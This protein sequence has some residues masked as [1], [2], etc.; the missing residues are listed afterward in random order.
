MFHT[1]TEALNTIPENILHRFTFIFVTSNIKE[2]ASF[3]KQPP[4]VFFKMLENSQE[5]KV[6]GLSLQIL[7]KK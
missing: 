1:C 6:T 7:L 3:K 4:Q 5:N 2:Q